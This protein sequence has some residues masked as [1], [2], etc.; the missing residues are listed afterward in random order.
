MTATVSSRPGIKR[1]T[2]ISLPKSQSH[3][4]LAPGI[5]IDPHDA[6]ADARSLIGRLD[7]ERGRHRI[8][9]GELARAGDQALGDRQAGGAKNR[10]WPSACASRA[11][12]R[13]RPNGCRGRRSIS[14]TPWIVPS[15]PPTPCKR[16]EDRRPGAGRARRSS[17]G[18]SRADIDR[19]DPVAVVDERL[20]AF[21]PLDSDTSRS[22]DQPPISNADVS[23][24]DAR[25]PYR[26]IN[27]SGRPIRRISHSSTTPEFS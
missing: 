10:P 24:H 22:G 23:A 27:G 9:F 16:V 17:A 8:A 1:S 11:P 21:P 7:D 6:D 5:V 4:L 12:R 3:D 2:S 26:P 18:R 14:S 25:L 15:S 20:G 13:A 19:A